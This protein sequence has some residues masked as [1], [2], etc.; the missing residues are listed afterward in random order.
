MAQKKDVRF[1]KHVNLRAFSSAGPNLVRGLLLAALAGLMG[2]KPAHGQIDSK[3]HQQKDAMEILTWTWA[4]YT[5][6]DGSKGFWNPKPV[7]AMGGTLVNVLYSAEDRPD[8][9]VYGALHP[10]KLLAEVMANCQPE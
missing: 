7:I 9:V 8:R 10:P 3:P 2:G 1:S 4:S 6:P 5:R